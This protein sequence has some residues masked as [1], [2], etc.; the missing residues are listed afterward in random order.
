MPSQ[1]G[2]FPNGDRSQES[3]LRS[4][5]ESAALARDRLRVT[6]QL[7]RLRDSTGDSCHR[8][9]TIW[10]RRTVLDLDGVRFLVGGR[11]I[12]A[13]P[14]ATNRTDRCWRSVAD[15]H[16]GVCDSVLYHRLS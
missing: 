14:S 6:V 5:R 3:S 8:R 15:V 7:H 12:H 9:S 1:I 2:E 4:T 11:R 16:R 10:T 13:Y